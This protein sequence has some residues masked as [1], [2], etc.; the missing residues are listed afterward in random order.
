MH[1]PHCLEITAPGHHGQTVDNHGRTQHIL[2]GPQSRRSV[3]LDG[4]HNAG[5]TDA[6]DAAATPAQI[7]PREF[8]EESIGSHCRSRVG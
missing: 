1:A 5:A 4:D 2:L 3:G 8:V 7:E 6:V